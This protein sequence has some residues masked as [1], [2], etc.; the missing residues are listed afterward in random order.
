M[1]NCCFI[2]L[3][4][5]PMCRYLHSAQVVPF[6]GLPDSPLFS[7]AVTMGRTLYVSHMF[8]H[9][10]LKRVFMYDLDDSDLRHENP[11]ERKIT[12]SNR[13][14][15]VVHGLVG[16]VQLMVPCPDTNT[17]YLLE[18]HTDF[19]VNEVV[20]RVAQDGTVLSRW[21]LD[22]PTLT[23]NSM[24][25]NPSGTL[26]VVTN[27]LEVNIYSTVNGHLVDTTDEMTDGNIN[28][29][30]LFSTAAFQDDTIESVIPVTSPTCY[31]GE[32]LVTDDYQCLLMVSNSNMSIFNKTRSKHRDIAINGSPPRGSTSRHHWYDKHRGLVFCVRNYQLSVACVTL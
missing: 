24:A 8:A 19:I 31:K 23:I 28:N 29:D 5:D 16:Y 32:I 4:T 27:Y 6:Y 22:R 14:P 11:I 12:C 18:D 10:I 2:F 26:M 9:N 15:L 25:L 20:H 3:S 21:S 1:L 7:C 17:L 30:E 13:R